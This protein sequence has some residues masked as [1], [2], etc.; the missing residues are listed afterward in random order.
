MKN[1]TLAIDEETL[2]QGREYAKRRNMSFNA[3]VRDILKK[4]VKPASGGMFEETF[5]IADEAHG[6]SEGRT[7]TREEI[8]ERSFGR[9]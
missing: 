9:E 8:H 2:E 5:R 4:T 7:W 3:L 6:N 1:I